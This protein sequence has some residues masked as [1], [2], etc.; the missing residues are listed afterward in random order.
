ME[1][2]RGQLIRTE[3]VRDLNVRRYPY[4]HP[5]TYRFIM[6]AIREGAH[7][8]LPQGLQHYKDGWGRWV[9]KR[10]IA[11][12]Y[13]SSTAVEN[14]IGYMYGYGI[15]SRSAEPNRRE[16]VREH[17]R[18]FIKMLRENCSPRLRSIFPLDD[19]PLDKP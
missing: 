18:T 14:E 7:R 11:F 15:N 3:T 9:K 17:V 6:A 4:A 16:A 5:I 12:V 19:I 1:R 13:F 10:N 8:K 2:D